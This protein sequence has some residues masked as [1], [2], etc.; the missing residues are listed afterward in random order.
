M[1]SE[2]MA[3]RARSLALGNDEIKWLETIIRNHM[4]IHY[5]TNRLEREG[6][7]PSRRA[8]YRFFRETGQAGMEVCMLALADLRATYEQTLPQETWA[9]AL[10]VVRT[11]L[12]AWYEKKEEQVTPQSLVNGND[13]MRALSLPPGKKI[14]ELLEAIRE[15]QAMGLVSSKEQALGLARK[16]M[17]EER[18]THQESL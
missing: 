11:L 8:I 3:G 14:G 15:A 7:P 18:K 2:V 13:L 12:E 5:H 6:K 16:K 10:E 1:G 17:E 9:A 4:R